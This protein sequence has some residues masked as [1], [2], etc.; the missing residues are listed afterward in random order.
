MIV[1]TG[2][3]GHI[4]NNLVRLL[5]SRGE[6]V[7]AMVLPGEDL[8]PLKGLA[9]EIVEGDVRNPSALNRAFQGADLVFHLA[10]VISLSPGKSELLHQVNVVGARNVAE[11]CLR[12]KVKRL[13][14]ASSIHALVEPPKGIC[15]N[16]TVE[17]D[18]NKISMEYSKTKAQGTLEVL[19]VVKQGLDAVIV[20]PV[21]VIGPFDFKPSEVGQMIIHFAK[22]RL[23]VSIQGGYDFA[24]VRDIAMGF[25]L[26]AEKGRTGQGY[27]L[28]GEWVSVYDILHA[29]GVVLGRTAPKIQ[30][31]TQFALVVARFLTWWQ[32]KTGMKP[33]VTTDMIETL[34]SNSEVSC[35]KAQQELGYVARPIRDSVR[36]S[37]DWFRENGKL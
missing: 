22:G 12:N 16:E 1:V 3:P 7:R 24:D 23:P 28:S 34:L 37:A 8:T 2:A 31:S 32:R 18:P 25:L 17:C 5:L 26:A 13:I 27:I 29:A 21:G 6:S 4:G 20:Y 15:I 19:E 36:D 30:I 11:A 35:A 9:V 33:I 10:S 14:Y